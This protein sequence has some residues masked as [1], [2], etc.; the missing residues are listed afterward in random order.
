MDERLRA[1]WATVIA[2][3]LRRARHPV[4][5]SHVRPD[6]DAWSSALGLATALRRLDIATVVLAH[7]PVAPHLAFLEGSDT[8]VL[9]DQDI[10]A[11]DPDV[12]VLVDCASHSRAGLLDADGTPQFPRAD[13]VVIDHHQNPVASHALA[14]IDPS[15]AAAAELGADVVEALGVPVDAALATT[16]LTGMLTDTA[17]FQLGTTTPRLLRRAASLLEAGA[18]IGSLASRLFR[19]RRKEAAALWGRTL[20]TLEFHAHGQVAC[21]TVRRLFLNETGGTDHDLN[22]RAA[23]LLGIEGVRVALL[24]REENDEETRI[25]IRTD[26]D[27]SAVDIV[28]QFGGGGHLHAAGCTI[29]GQPFA[30]A[31]ARVIAAAVALVEGEGAALLANSRLNLP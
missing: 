23:Y 28:R 14:F 3:R 8:V 11:L 9:L 21:A 16:L 22:G 20:A 19:T 31:K 2:S 17:S 13:L 4:I 27:L 24:I 18:E 25:S 7:E 29:T 10:S 5:A 30:E 26:D 1:A 6:G 12:V 15:A